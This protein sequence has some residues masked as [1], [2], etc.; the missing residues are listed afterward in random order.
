MRAVVYERF[1]GP[2]ELR[3][4]PPPRCPADGVVVAV[5]ATGLCRSDWHGWQGHDP[6][7]PLPNVPGHEL[8]G[9]VVEVGSGVARWSP[10]DR[11]TAPF[12]C[13]CG[14]CA[15][16]LRGD[17]QV[18]ER[19]QQPGFT[20]AGSFAD[21]VALR[22]ADVNLVAVPDAVSDEA[23]AGLGCRF[24]TAYR[25]VTTV[26]A[27]QAG[28]RVAVH[29]CGGVGLAAVMIA[30]AR[31]ATVVGIDPSPRSRAIA[32]DL[33][34]TR[35][36]E[37]ADGLDEID[38]SVD[39]FG[40]PTTMRASIATLRPRGRHVQVGLLGADADPA[41]PMGAVVARELQLLGSHG[42]AAHEYPAMLADIAS[43][44]LAPQR[45]LGEVIGLADAP[46][47]LADLGRPGAGAGGVTIIRT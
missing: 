37:S 2:I 43:G 7:I 8:V 24:A 18:C 1:S 25:A 16:C 3:E 26:G 11:V 20:H 35:V 23:A 30:A 21:L 41:V 6:D 17:Q 27:V 42:M 28:E 44:A 9:T 46:A 39:A 12:V 36:A 15:T 38:C 32:L 14:T 5:S 34:A 22:Y 45:L 13:A 29:G 19:Q 40:S 33:G 10:G 4:V 31:G 47:R